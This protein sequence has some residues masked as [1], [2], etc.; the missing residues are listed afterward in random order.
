[1]Q[2]FDVRIFRPVAVLYSGGNG[3]DMRIYVELAIRAFRQLFAYQTAMLAGIFTNSIF[4]IVLSAV[5]LALF[6]SRAEGTSVEGFTAAQTV[7]YTWLGQALIAPLLLFGWWEIVQTIRTGAVVT[8]LLKPTSYFG[9]WLSRDLGRAAGHTL[10]RGAPTLLMGTILYDLVW[11]ESPARA[12]AFLVSVVF[13]VI[14]SFCF[15]FM[16][17]LWGFWVLDHRGIAGISLV[18]VGVCSGHLLPIAWYPDPIRD[19]FNVLPFRAILMLPVEIWL[20]QVT[21]AEGLGLQVFWMV[22]MIVASL[23]LLSVAERKVVVQ[24]G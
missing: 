3:S 16:M 2:R 7:T 24:G 4:G 22:L 10:L 11:P 13:A 8:D 6:Q 17:N 19:V 20:G 15:R 21:I 18:L 12:V 23:W 14:V 5:Y 9:Y 1:M